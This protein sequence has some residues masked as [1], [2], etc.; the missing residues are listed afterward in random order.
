MHYHC[1]YYYMH[2][3]RLPYMDSW[4]SNKD[5]SKHQPVLSSIRWETLHGVSNKSLMCADISRNN[6]YTHNGKLTNKC[7]WNDSPCSGWSNKSSNTIHG[8]SQSRK[9][10][11][12]RT[13]PRQTYDETTQ[14]Q[15]GSRRY[16]Q[17]TQNFRVEVN[18]IFKHTTCHKQNS[19]QV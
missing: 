15:L 13:Y 5:K 4:Y 9:G 8:Y 18:N 14:F 2:M 7:Q 17:Q 11:K 16:I 6:T 10:T 19:H 1:I 12:C 3:Y